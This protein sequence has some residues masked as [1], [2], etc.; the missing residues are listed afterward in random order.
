MLRP[1][2]G[3]VSCI[4]VIQDNVVAAGG[5]GEISSSRTTISQG[6]PDLGSDWSAAEQQAGLGFSPAARTT[7]GRAKAAAAAAAAAGREGLTMPQLIRPGGRPQV[8]T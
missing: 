7:T 1:N 6:S 4:C 3:V 2:K 5:D 8:G